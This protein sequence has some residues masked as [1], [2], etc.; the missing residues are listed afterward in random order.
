[1]RHLDALDRPLHGRLH[2]RVVGGAEG[3]LPREIGRPAAQARAQPVC[4]LPAH[5]HLP[6]GGGDGVRG[7][8]RF[9]EGRL[10]LRRPAVAAFGGGLKGGRG[11][12]AGIRTRREIAGVVS[13]AREGA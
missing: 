7:S 9:E 10:P 13:H 4:R 5:L 8:E 6:R 2:E 3:G 11:Q 1:M 12:V